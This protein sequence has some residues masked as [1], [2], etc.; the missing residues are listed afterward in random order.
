V[1][2][3][4]TGGAE[5]MLYKLLKSLAPSRCDPVIISLA[6]GDRPAKLLRDLGIPVWELGL[7]ASGPLGLPRAAVHGRR[8]LR[9]FKPA[10]ISGWMY[11]GNL[12]AYLLGLGLRTPLLWNIRQS[13]NLAGEKPA[14]RSVI[15]AG[16]RLSSAP[17]RIVY[18]SAAAREQH[19]AIG[20]RDEAACVLP[21]GFEVEI[22][23]RDPLER[24]RMRHELG[25][26]DD[27]CVIGHL[28]RFHPMKDQLGLIEAAR[29]V[30]GERADVLFLLAGAGLGDDNRQLAQAIRQSGLEGKVRLLGPTQQPHSLLSACDLFCLPSAWG[31]GFPNAVGEAMASELPCVVTSVG[32]GPELV[33]DTGLVVGPGDRAA[34]A[35]ALLQLIRA[36]AASRARL[37]K[38]ARERIQACYSLPAVATRYAEV[39]DAALSA[40]IRAA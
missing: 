2:G 10:L 37:G 4:R 25:V 21:N 26:G 14:T 1:S 3:L 40:E 30:I 35:A 29:G 15:R 12:A 34:L 13:L 24:A 6:T 23:R 39:F 7:D 20:Y 8:A 33:G 19:R 17:R 31:E 9:G 36:G 11:H 5:M 38:L 28:A 32:A 16:A 18:V 22:F 27:T